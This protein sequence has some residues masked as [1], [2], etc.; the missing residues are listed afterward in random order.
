MGAAVVE[1]SITAVAPT[2]T[3]THIDNRQAPKAQ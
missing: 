2:L 3:L 1:L